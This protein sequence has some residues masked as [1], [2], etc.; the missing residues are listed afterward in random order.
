MA[1]NNGLSNN[2]MASRIYDRKD[3]LYKQSMIKEILDMYA[4]EVRKAVMSGERVQIT[5]VGTIIPELKTHIGRYNMPI[6]NQH[7]DNPPPYTKIRISRNQSIKEAMDEQLIR[8]MNDGIFGL[9]KLSFTKQQIGIL[10]DSGYIPEDYV[11][12][13]MEE[14][15]ENPCTE[16]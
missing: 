15:E 3:N 14:T 13:G 11:F 7:G 8:N 1:V 12:D 10:K 9:D 16:Q 6:C 4:D 2:K 5:R